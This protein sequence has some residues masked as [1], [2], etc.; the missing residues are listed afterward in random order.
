[1]DMAYNGIGNWTAC[2]YKN[3]GVSS[4]TEVTIKCL[5][6][7]NTYE[8]TNSNKNDEGKFL[9]ATGSN[10]I[11]FRDDTIAYESGDIFEI[12][13]HNVTNKMTGEKTDYTYRSVFMSLSEVNESAVTDIELNKSEINLNIGT[14]ERIFAKIIPE[15]A[16]D[17]LIKFTSKDD[18]I[19]TVRQDGTV[20]GIKEGNTEILVECG[21]I[22]KT[23]NVIVNKYLKGDINNDGKITTLDLNYGLA[24][25]LK[26]NL[27]QE[28]EQR[29]DVTGDNKYTTLD[30]N[31]LLGYLLGKI[32]EL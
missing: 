3:Y 1:M 2:F 11:T 23:V 24:K 17:K 32:K 28:E 31:K 20:V 7:G 5:N 9:Q 12:T 25:L 15:D 4:D 10:L 19:A 21:E 29:G 30:L 18:N 27:T 22:T 6:S 8:I 14:N 13:L 16:T 26:G